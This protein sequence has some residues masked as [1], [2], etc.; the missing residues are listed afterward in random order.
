MSTEVNSVPSL[1]LTDLD[2]DQRLLALPGVS[3]LVFTGEGCASCRWARRHLGDLDLP[4]ERL[5]WVDAGRNGG[6]VERYGVFHLPALFVVRDGRFHGALNVPLQRE[7]LRGAVLAG[8]SGSP[9][10]LP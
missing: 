3:L 1:E 7:A 4:V 6:L 9:E 5:C 10:E 8:L 2:A